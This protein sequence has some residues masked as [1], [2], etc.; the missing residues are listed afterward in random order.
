MMDCWNKRG[1]GPG[2][3][4][5]RQLDLANDGSLDSQDVGELRALQLDI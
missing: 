5:T 1:P 3:L 2:K 4:P